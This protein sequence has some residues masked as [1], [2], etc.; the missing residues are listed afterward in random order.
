M[1]LLSAR[2][3]AVAHCPA[4]NTRLHSGLCPVLKLIS[5]KLV[6]SDI[7]ILAHA[8]H[9]R[10]EEMALL[11]ARGAAVVHCPAANTRLHSGLCPVLKL[12]SDQQQAGRGI[13]N[14]LVT[15]TS[16]LMRWFTCATSRWRCCRRAARPWRTVPP[17]TPGSTRGCVSTNIYSVAVSRPQAH[18]QQAGRGIR[19]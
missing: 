2:G 4:A 15:H 11:S 8:V 14:R 18:Q 16:W 10:D 17:P 7:Y 19:N 3:A 6:V 1:T 9:L 12:I 5:N 13:R